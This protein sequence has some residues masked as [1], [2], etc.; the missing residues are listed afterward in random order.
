MSDLTSAQTIPD[1]ESNGGT[2]QISLISVFA[3]I[4]LTA[5]M[6]GTMI[7]IGRLAGMTTSEVLQLGLANSL[8]SLPVGLVWLV[9]L[10]FSIANRKR[11]GRRATLMIVAL[12]GLL[13]TTFVSQVV[14]M[15]MIHGVGNAGLSGAAF[16]WIHFCVAIVMAIL[17]AT[18]WV[19][20]LIAVFSRG[21][22]ITAN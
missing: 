12:G 2:F 13:L 21:R 14:F 18:F 20:V 19:L 9:G 4:T 5:V 15:V 1:Q 22:A 10:T 11:H 6:L 7:G 17:H 16:G 3:V 8:Y